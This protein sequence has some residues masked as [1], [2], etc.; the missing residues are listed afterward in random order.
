[1]SRKKII[2]IGKTC[3]GK[4]YVRDG[5]VKSGFIAD[6]SYTSRPPRPNEIHGIDYKFIT[7]NEFEERISECLFY[8]WVQYDEH[9]YGTSKYGWE[10]SDI[11]IME[12]DGIEKIF[13]CDKQNCVIIYIN[14]PQDIRT[15]RMKERGWDEN[16]IIERIKIDE[17]KFK[18]FNDIKF[19][20]KHN[21]NIVLSSPG[22]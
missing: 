18:D 6:V 20:L 15:K 19:L 7:K 14:T 22:L 16:K 17:E 5:F 12:P 2:L 4:N 11:F 3:S 13:N 8:E 1:M 21:I 9:Y 10:H